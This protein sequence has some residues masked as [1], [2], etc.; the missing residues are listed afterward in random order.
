MAFTDRPKI[1]E[2]LADSE[3]MCLQFEI[4]LIKLIADFEEEHDY[5]FLPYELDDI[6]LKRIRRNHQLY[7]KAEFKHGDK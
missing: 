1:N 5:K 2:R 4:K 6:F 3:D 7:L